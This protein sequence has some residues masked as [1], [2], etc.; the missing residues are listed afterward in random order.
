MIRGA[1]LAATLVAA[2]SAPLL[3]KPAQPDPLT[4]TAHVVQPGET[5]GGIAVRAQVPRVLIIEANHLQPPYAIKPGQKLVIPRR[6]SYTVKAG[7]TGFGIAMDLGVPWSAIAAANGLDAKAAVKPG[8][9]LKIPTMAAPR[10]AAAPAP[11]PSPAP[12][13]AASPA[14]A[15]ST[16]AALPPDT[17]APRM[18]WPLHGEVKRGFTARDGAQTYHDGID[19][20]A[21]KGDSVHAA[22]EGKVIYAGQGPKEYG[23]TVIVYHSGRW[24]T[25]YAFLDKV[26]V[27]DGQHVLKG[28][29]LGLAGQ[30][31]LAA[32][33]QLHF[34]VRRNRAAQDPIT[35]LPS[36]PASPAK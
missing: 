19:I 3:A 26:T 28:Q 15:A 24:T 9:V 30:S 7:E 6:R 20:A 1:V 12:T 18:I 35:Y 21:A 22:A 23:Q 14:A 13:A 4:E 25:T 16:T 5:L 11:A 27:K 8:Q 36:L 17:R 31:G 29:Q 10:A 34:E 32:S 2:S 33:P